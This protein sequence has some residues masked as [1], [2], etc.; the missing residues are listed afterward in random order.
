MQITIPDEEFNRI[1]FEG[2]AQF[3]H[4]L[5][6]HMN[7]F[8]KYDCKLD[9]FE[10]ELFPNGKEITESMAAFD[11]VRKHII[12]ADSILKNRNITLVSVGD[13]NTP[14]TAGLFAFLTK[15]ECISVDPLMKNEDWDVKRLTTY[16]SRIEELDLEYK[17]V[18]ILG[19]HSHADMKATLDHIKGT[20]S[21]SMLSIPCCVPYNYIEPDLIYNDYG[22]WS[23][24]NEVRIWRDI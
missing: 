16:K 14:R 19:V 20:A 8:L 11:G 22:I 17:N 21:R 18:I 3:I 23:P 10:R 4:Q 6:K 24:K 1:I 5:T 12:K 13:G 9:I 7:R 15:W 2:H